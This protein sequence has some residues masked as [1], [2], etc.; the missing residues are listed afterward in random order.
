MGYHVDE[1]ERIMKLQWLLHILFVEEITEQDFEIVYN[2]NKE[3]EEN[4][5]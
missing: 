4:D 2:N 3:G 5:W 1:E